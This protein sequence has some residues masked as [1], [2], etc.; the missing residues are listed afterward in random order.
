MQRE[1]RDN[2]G[3]RTT[4]ADAARKSPDPSTAG[5]SMHATPAHRIPY[6]GSRDRN[7]AGSTNGR[8]ARQ[9]PQRV[10]G[11][12]CVRVLRRVQSRRLDMHTGI[13]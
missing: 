9:Q 4:V 7:P 3:G 6:T 2:A 1:Y 11:V 5:P 8:A 13:P 10:G 12:W